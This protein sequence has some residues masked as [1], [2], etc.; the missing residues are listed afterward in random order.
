MI[1]N[2]SAA[3]GNLLDNYRKLQAKVDQRWQE[4]VRGYGPMIHCTRGCHDCCCHIS[5]FAVEAAALALAA[6]Q[7][8]ASKIAARRTA[9]PAA[10]D[11]EPCP[12]LDN[13]LCRLYN[14]RPLICRTQGLALLVRDK[15]R[16]LLDWCPLNF[17]SANQV[18]AAA[19]LD[20]DRL[21]QALAAVNGLFVHQFAPA[22]LWPERIGVAEAL[23]LSIP[24]HI[25]DTD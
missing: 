5:V 17:G 9:L 12:L 3:M 21:N 2:A 8:P 23:R 25:L 11:K 14:D 16:V 15:D 13:G 20:L 6:Q 4:V 10:A 22:R 1:T 24:T 18:P 7:W 19:I